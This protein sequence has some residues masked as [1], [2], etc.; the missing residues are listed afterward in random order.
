MSKAG[1]SGRVADPPSGSTPLAEETPALRALRR[2]YE[3]QLMRM[4]EYEAGGEE[5]AALPGPPPEA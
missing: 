3:E 1:I 2:Y 5:P 4:R